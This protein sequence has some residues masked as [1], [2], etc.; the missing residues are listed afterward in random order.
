MSNPPQAWIDAEPGFWKP[1]TAA[2]AP[3]AKT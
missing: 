3:A 1:T 2:K